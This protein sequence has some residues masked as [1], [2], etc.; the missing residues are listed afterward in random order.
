[1]TE[2]EECG[3]PHRTEDLQLC[4]ACG[5]DG[6][7]FVC[8]TDHDCARLSDTDWDAPSEPEETK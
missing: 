8:I 6:L 7:C 4:A 1:M 2:C 3:E 5:T